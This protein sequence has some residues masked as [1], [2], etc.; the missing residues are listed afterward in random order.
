MHGHSHAGHGHGHGH[1]HGAPKPRARAG[2][3]GEH[4]KHDSR[5]DA[6]RS[7]RALIVALVLTG[8]F[9]VVEVVAGFVSGSLALLAD[10]GHMLGDSGALVV[11]LAAAQIAL[12]PRNPQKTYGYRRAEVVGALLNAMA[13]FVAA[14]WIVREGAERLGAPPEVDADTMLAT[15]SAGLGIN[16][17]AAFIL[18]RGS[19]GNI[20]VRAALLHVLGDALGSVAAIVA[21]VLLLFL[22]WR[23]ADPIAS[24][25]I[26]VLLFIG[27]IRMVRETTH[28]LMEGTPEGLDPAALERTIL[29]TEGVASVHDLHVW[30][31]TPGEPVLTAH[32]VLEPGAHGTDVARL[33]G[34]R[35]L[36]T[37]KV[38]HVT[39]Q[40]EAPEPADALVQLRISKRPPAP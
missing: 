20:N 6:E 15:A 22:G 3:A 11:S 14:I 7:R 39:I 28:V 9:M 16:L 33:V 32:V 13:L 5:A 17:I 38:D 4:E 30:S 26:S 31:L 25:A 29:E 21:G 23:L 40:P 2:D 10:A 1:G 37:H 18:S 24:M 36:D 34:Q 27:A 12:R 35:L 19:R 8:S